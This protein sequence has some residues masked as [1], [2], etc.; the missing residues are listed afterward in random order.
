VDRTLVRLGTASRV[1]DSAVRREFERAY[2]TPG[3]K[4]LGAA[5]ALAT[6]AILS[7]YLLDAIHADLPWLGGVQTARV[8]VAGTCALIAALCWTKVDTATRYYGPIFSGTVIAVIVAA[9]LISYMRHSTDPPNVLLW[10]VERTLTICVVVV[11]GFSRLTA[12]STMMLISVV[13]IIVIT[14]SLITGSTD[15]TSHLVR[16]SIQLLI[17]SICC[18]FLRRKH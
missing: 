16:M 12:L 6:C 15:L 10:S 5:S 4:Y 18:Y 1:R 14:L 8:L 13:P 9:C 3:V 17:V 11:A 2:R 7:Y